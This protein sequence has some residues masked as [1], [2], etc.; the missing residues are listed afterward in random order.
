MAL[1][2]IYDEIFLKQSKHR[3][4]VMN[5]QTKIEQKK[6][7]LRTAVKIKICLCRP[8]EFVFVKKTKHSAPIL[9]SSPVSPMVLLSAAVTTTT[10]PGQPTLAMQ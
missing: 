9:T 5:T 10:P 3:R 8:N 4:L 6:I 2:C 1:W 7:A